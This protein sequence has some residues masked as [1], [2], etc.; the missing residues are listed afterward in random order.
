MTPGT[1]VVSRIVIR[2]EQGCLMKQLVAVLFI[3]C[4]AVGCSDPTIGTVTGT[5]TVDGE[6]AETGSVAFIPT[7]GKGSTA[8]GKIVDG[9]YT[10]VVAVG[11]SRVEVR[12]PKIIGEQRLYDTKDSPVA[13]VWE[14]SLPEKYHNESELTYDVPS[15]KSEKN[16]DLTTK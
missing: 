14:E 7:D 15:G 2:F 1:V 9:S 12:V 4:V 10:A 13:P 16:F 11:V 3:S 6:P 5:I 8:G